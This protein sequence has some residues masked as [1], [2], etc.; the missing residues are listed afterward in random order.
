M[1]ARLAEM[2]EIALRGGRE[3]M[4][5][6]E[7]GGAV[8]RKADGSPV[9][10]ADICCEA[11]ILEG[12]R[13]SAPDIPV[14]AEEAAATGLVPATCELFF[15]VDPLDGTREFINRNGEFTVNI[16]L[17]ENGEPVA[18][19][20]YAPALGLL[21]AGAPHEGACKAWVS[22]GG[23]PGPSQ[24]IH[25]RE[26]PEAIVAIGSRSHGS[27]QTIGWLQRFDIERFT[28]LGSSLKFCLIAEGAA[29]VYPRLGR[30]MEWDTAAGD[31]ILRAADGMVATLDGAPLTYGKRGQSDDCDF[32]NPWFVA[33][34]DPGLRRRA[35]S[36]RRAGA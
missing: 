32:A 22:T 29:D 14:V 9:T 31:A 5:V 20:V 16:A 26:A 36:A 8:E 19:V 4:R 6:Y 2:I 18:G 17:I 1:R 10:E 13:R 23:V 15:L 11:V 35:P 3:V 28:S 24:R 21:Y 25:V 7:E 27:P 34:G 33:W 12:L 30:T